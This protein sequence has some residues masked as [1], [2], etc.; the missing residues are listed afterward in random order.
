MVL[1]ECVYDYRDD[2]R[3]YTGAFV[4]VVFVTDVFIL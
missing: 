2:N 3:H 1:V 4:A